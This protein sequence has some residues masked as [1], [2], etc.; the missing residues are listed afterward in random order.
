MSERETI[1]DLLREF[2]GA[3]LQGEDGFDSWDID[4]DDYLERTIDEVADAQAEACKDSGGYDGEEG[5]TR[6]PVSIS[7]TLYDEDRD[8]VVSAGAEFISGP[9]TPDCAPAG[10]FDEDLND[11]YPVHGTDETVTD[12]DELPSPGE[13]GHAWTS[14]HSMVGGL[15]NNPGVYGNSGGVKI[16]EV[17]SRCGLHRHTDTW[18]QSFTGTGEP[19]ETVRFDWE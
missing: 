14:P 2:P 9:D 8:I 4:P 10:E 1:A 17:C 3:D 5:D 13:D 6:G 12:E 18:D 19:V 15:E 7:V 16:H 11:V